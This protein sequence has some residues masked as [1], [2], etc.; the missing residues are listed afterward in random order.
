[1]R[2]LS[3][4]SPHIAR[5]FLG[6]VASVRQPDLGATTDARLRNLANIKT[7]MVNACAY[8]TAH[9]SIFG[10]GLGISDE[11]LE[12]LGSDAYKASPLF[13]ERDKAVIAWAEAMTRNTAQRD[14]VVWG[15]MKRLFTDTEI[16][17]ISMACAMFNMIN[18]LNDSFSTDLETV[19]YNKKQWNAVTGLSVDEIEDYASRFSTSGP[20]QRRG[21]VE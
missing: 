8:C 14:Q 3:A 10:Q 11:E 7:S 1:M 2:I 18:R 6:L 16:V 20:A 4:H 13:D 21:T 17:E 12:V 15:E 9:T 19:D 5:W